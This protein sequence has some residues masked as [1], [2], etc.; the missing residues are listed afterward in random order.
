M[1]LEGKSKLHDVW[2]CDPATDVDNVEEDEEE[3]F[4]SGEVL[5]VELPTG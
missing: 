5:M 4:H 3:L 2:C 1:V